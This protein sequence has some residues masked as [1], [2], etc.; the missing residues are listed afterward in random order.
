MRGYTFWKAVC[1]NIKRRPSSQWSPSASYALKIKFRPNGSRKLQGASE[2]NSK[3]YS[4]FMARLNPSNSDRSSPV[5]K[6]EKTWLNILRVW[7]CEIANQIRSKARRAISW[8]GSIILKNL[9]AANRMASHFF[10]GVSD[11]IS[12]EVPVTCWAAWSSDSMNIISTPNSNL[13]FP[14]PLNREPVALQHQC[15]SYIICK[16][17]PSGGTSKK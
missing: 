16:S 6:C 11:R 12:P 13:E 14:L 10:G 17:S 9:T 1:S 7:N 8:H 15:I 3:R 5:A 4:R 2:S